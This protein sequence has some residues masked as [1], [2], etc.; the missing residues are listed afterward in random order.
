MQRSNA[1]RSQIIGGDIFLPRGFST[2]AQNK[3]F[4]L[5]FQKN[6]TTLVVLWQVLIKLPG[7]LFEV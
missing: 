5:I 4:L 1:D 6:F 3:R 2:P 7:K